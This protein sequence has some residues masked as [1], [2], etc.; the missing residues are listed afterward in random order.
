MPT[1]TGKFQSSRLTA[2]AMDIVTHMIPNESMNQTDIQDL[3]SVS[4]KLEFKSTNRK[5]SKDITESGDL[6]K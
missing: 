3:L 2:N 1:T 6:Y 5:P 4:N